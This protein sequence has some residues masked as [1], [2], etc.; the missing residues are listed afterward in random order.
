MTCD[1]VKICIVYAQIIYTF[2]IVEI[3]KNEVRGCWSFGDLGGHSSDPRDKWYVVHHRLFSIFTQATM[4]W[5]PF[6]FCNLKQCVLPPKLCYIYEPQYQDITLVWKLFNSRH[7][8]VLTLLAELHRTVVFSL[9]ITISQESDPDH[10]NILASDFD[11]TPNFARIL[12]RPQFLSFSHKVPYL[13]TM[14]ADSITKEIDKHDAG[15]IIARYTPLQKR[16]ICSRQIRLLALLSSP[17][18]YSCI[19]K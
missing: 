5:H 4:K 13:H 19:R 6:Q 12:V 7:V 9:K 15:R 16:I 14:R 17:N 11:L 3:S 8:Y 2:V 18:A 1:R 10:I